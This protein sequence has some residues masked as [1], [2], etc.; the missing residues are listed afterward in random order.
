V[1]A[2]FLLVIGYP[3]AVAVLIRLKRVLVERRVWWFAALEAATVSITA[4]WLLHR[5]PL[6]AAVNGAALLGLAIAWL[7]TGQRAGHRG[8]KVH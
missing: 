4:G 8:R 6:A 1:T 2:S 7:V 3:V 5:R